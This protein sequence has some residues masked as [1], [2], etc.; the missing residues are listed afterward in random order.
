LRLAGGLGLA[1]FEGLDLVVADPQ[2]RA[3]AAADPGLPAAV[4]A[5]LRL[6]GVDADALGRQ[7]LGQLRAGHVVALGDVLDLLLDFLVGGDDRD[8]L[9]LLDPTQFLHLDVL[10]DQ[11]AQG[12]L[13]QLGQVLL[14]RLHA[15]RH[16]QQ[17][18]ALH[19]VVAGDDVVVDDRRDAFRQRIGARAAGAAAAGASTVGGAAGEAS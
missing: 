8:L 15:R 11:R 17:A 10:V 19:Q 6:P 12:F 18:H 9:S 3:V 13:L 4:G 7:L 1:A 5:D 16:H 14:G 2:A